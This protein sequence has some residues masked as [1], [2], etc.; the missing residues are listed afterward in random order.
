MHADLDDPPRP[1]GGRLKVA[2]V[3]CEAFPEP[4]A[5]DALYVHALRQ[6]GAEVHVVPWNGSGSAPAL[7]GIDVAVL[8]SPWDY[9]AH[10]PDFMAWL[11][12]VERLSL[13]LLNPPSLVRWN[14]DKRY[15]LDLARAGL[16]VPRT[17]ALIP[18]EGPVQWRTAL[19]QV[20]A[21]D[22]GPAVLKPCWGGSGVAVGLT[23]LDTIGRDVAAAMEEAPGRPWLVQALVPGIAAEGETSF[24]FVA[25]QFAHAV[26]TRPAAGDFRVN[27]RY[28]PRPPERIDPQ[29]GAVADAA[30]VLAALPGR[31]A[32]LYARIDGAP[33]SDG[34]F[35]YLEAEVIDP[36]LFLDL[37]PA[38]AELLA[39][40]T[41]AAIKEQ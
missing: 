1:H 12:S 29:A 21:G 37:A 8:R 22:G 26:R 9:P 27:A 38:T 36:T 20:G 18:E 4:S 5:S 15:L 31:A 34:R 41:L 40:A 39:R 25:G 3:T 32:P 2:V 19:A 6:L 16:S 30:R 7:A 33:H 17:A 23:S 11:D 10:T 13:R 24:I 28:A 35:V 14:I